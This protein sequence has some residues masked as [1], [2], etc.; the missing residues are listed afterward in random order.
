MMKRKVLGLILVLTMLMTTL[1]GCSN[2]SSGGSGF[3][4][5]ETAEN[6]NSGANSSGK[7]LRIGLSND[8]TTLDYAHNYTISNFQVVDNINDFLLVFD[9]NGEMQPSLC[10]SWEAVD[11][12]TY[13]YQIRDDAVFSD[14]TPMTVDDVVYSMERIKNPETA[15]DMNWAYANV[16]SI[17][18]TGEWEVT[19]KLSKPD[20]TWQYIPATPGCEITSKTY[21][22]SK[23]DDFGNADAL[24][25]GTG[26]YKVESWQ[27]GS[28]I[29]LTKNE[30]YWGEEPYYDKIV[31]TVISDESSMALAMTSGQIDFCIPASTDLASTYSSGSN[32]N[33]Y[34]VDSIG[35][36][37]LSFNCS[38]GQCM[39]ANLRK[40]I[41]SCV[42]TVTLLESQMGDYAEAPTAS[43]FGS[44]LYVL[45]KEEWTSRI[46]ALDNYDYDL[47][48]AKKYLEESSYDGSELNLIIIEGNTAYANY[49]Q[50]IQASCAEIGIK[51]KIEKVTTS[52]YYA[53][54]YG[55]DLDGDGNRKYDMMINRW[56]P[57]YIDPAGD[58]VVFYDSVNA[59]S[60]GANYA[61][62]KN[63]EVD[64]L[65]DE[66]AELIDNKERSELLIQAVELANA[67]S[68]YKALYY[69]KTI[70]CKLDSIDYELP[71]FW[72]Y[73]FAAKDFKPAE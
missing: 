68:P 54:A 22:E 56:V 63:E 43:P 32:C 36:T 50:V 46:N 60:G 70:Y 59:G 18:A 34:S 20:A 10:T 64:A 23:G 12:T 33:I 53:H 29:V 7:V 25:I 27:T 24:T 30:Y 42:D 71:G 5:G 8:I 15:S 44:G 51:I 38:R 14:G 19:V 55:N 39:D 21:C 66:Q 37:L 3:A 11:S 57:D 1:V 52:E 62:Y 45:D 49:A 16:A 69:Q 65:L 13:V 35:C 67:D 2:S 58:L 4:G 26:A 72:L 6:G 61:C 47:K 40:A 41:A 48:E 28:E 9:S 17:E 73:S 31:Y